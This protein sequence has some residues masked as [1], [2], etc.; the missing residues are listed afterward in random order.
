MEKLRNILRLVV[1]AQQQEP[2][3]GRD[4]IVAVDE[5]FFTRKRRARGGLAGRQTAGLD[6]HTRR[7]EEQLVAADWRSFRIGKRA[8]SNDF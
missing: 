1:G 8:R 2:L 5:T 4:R 6:L 3:G 7:R